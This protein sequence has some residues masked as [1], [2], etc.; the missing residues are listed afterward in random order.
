MR[1][2]RR[3]L[4]S[5]EFCGDSCLGGT[6]G[7]CFGQ[8][9]LELCDLGLLKPSQD[10]IRTQLKARRGAPKLVLEGHLLGDFCGLPTL[11]MLVRFHLGLCRRL[12]NL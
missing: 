7:P 1:A 4:H 10:T 2:Q 6:A 5:A 11:P 8:L 9:L 12:R 3:R